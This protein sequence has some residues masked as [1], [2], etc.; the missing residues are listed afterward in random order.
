MNITLSGKGIINVTATIFAPN[1]QSIGKTKLIQISSAEYQGF[2]RT[3]VLVAF[4]LLVLLSISNI[5]RRRR[6]AK[7]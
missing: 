1:G 7:K 3:L 5:V 4:G 2:A 6:E